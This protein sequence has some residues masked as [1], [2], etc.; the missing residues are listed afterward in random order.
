M[1]LQRM[2]Y[3]FEAEILNGKWVVVV[4]KQIDRNY[5]S[6]IY[7]TDRIKSGEVLWKRET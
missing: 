3:R 1:G 2:V 7:V 5:V 4:V 6:T